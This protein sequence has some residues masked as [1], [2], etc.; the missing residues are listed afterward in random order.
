M[1]SLQSRDDLF[2]NF[3][4]IDQISVAFVSLNSIELQL[5]FGSASKIDPHWNVICVAK[6]VPMFVRKCVKPFTYFI[7]IT[8][9]IV[10]NKYIWQL[11]DV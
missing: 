3:F 5:E 1:M 8:L 10:V 11:I 7:F 9:F 2:V 4:T 6:F